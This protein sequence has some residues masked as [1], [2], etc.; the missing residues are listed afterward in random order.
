MSDGGSWDSEYGRFFLDWYAGMLERHADAMLAAAA[1]ALH[2]GRRPRRAAGVKQVL[3]RLASMTQVRLLLPDSY[4][5]HGG[6]PQCIRA[7]RPA[8]KRCAPTCAA[9]HLESGVSYLK[10]ASALHKIT[11]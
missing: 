2:G 7:S 11:H 9:V 4:P 3:R 1:G 6:R 10:K 5:F 8:W